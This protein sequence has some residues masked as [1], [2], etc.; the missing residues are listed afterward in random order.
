MA[1]HL[2][3]LIRMQGFDDLIGE[4]EQV[5]EEL[6]R[7]LEGM[8]ASM[9]EAEVQVAA[10]KARLEEN[11]KKQKGRE[12]EIKTNQQTIDKYQA[13]LATIKT[14]KEYRALYSEINHLK[15]KNSHIDEEILVLMEDETARKEDLRLAEEEQKKAR[16]DLSANEDVLRK[17]ISAV[18]IEI[19]QLKAQRNDIAKELPKPL[20]SKY[21]Q[22]ITHKNRRA[23]QAMIDGSCTGCGFRARP[24]VQ[25]D[26]RSRGKIIYCENCG[27][28]LYEKM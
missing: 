9:R 22:L 28:I 24:Q 16:A 17:E 8:H 27:R 10:C 12:M 6:P 14:N 1:D 26:V 13:Q 20:V 18:D 15:E 23:V 25:I 7:R 11:Q 2:E 5:K 4:K 19:D 3:Q 21:V